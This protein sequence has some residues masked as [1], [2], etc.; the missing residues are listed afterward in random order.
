[1][2]LPCPGNWE[3]ANQTNHS[4]VISRETKKLLCRIRSNSRT[5]KDDCIDTRNVH[6][7]M[8][9]LLTP[10][11]FPY[12]AGHYRGAADKRCLDDYSVGI[13]SDPLV[14]I[15]PK[16]VASAMSLLAKAISSAHRV[17]DE[18]F[19][20]PINDKNK[21]LSELVDFTA[22]LFVDFLTIHPYAN[23]NGHMSRFV[24]WGIFGRY[25]YEFDNHFDIEPGPKD[26]DY[27][28][29]I[30]NHRRKYDNRLRLRILCAL[31]H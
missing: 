7:K 18:K 20:D 6:K 1:M 2:V 14:G 13:P 22:N 3:Y 8:F 15:H 23:G 26:A 16:E 12:Y 19:S 25:G 9:K 5:I 31:K 11:G 29:S 21:I 4:F 17:F 10:K 30:F 27:Y 24:L 28:D